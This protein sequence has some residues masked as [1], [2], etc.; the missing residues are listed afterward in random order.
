MLWQDY[1]LPASVGEALT[2]LATYHGEACVVAG[3]TDLILEIQQ[4]H[5]PLQAVTVPKQPRRMPHQRPHIRFG[6][7]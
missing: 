5:R 4:G 7:R 6:D 3:G 2:L 1:H